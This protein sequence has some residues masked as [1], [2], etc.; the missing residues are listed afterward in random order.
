VFKE[1]FKCFKFCD[2]IAGRGMIGPKM[3]KDENV[4]GIKYLIQ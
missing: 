2:G 1:R 3:L 4:N